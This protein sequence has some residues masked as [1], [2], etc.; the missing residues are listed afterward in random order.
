[1]FSGESRLKMVS[2]ILDTINP[3]I[4][5]STDDE[6]DHVRKETV[7]RKRMTS[8]THKLNNHSR[9]GTELVF[10]PE[11]NVPMKLIDFKQN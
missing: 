5:M 3:N 10:N 11:F 2:A 9:V 8:L 6:L 7:I 1:M 4:I